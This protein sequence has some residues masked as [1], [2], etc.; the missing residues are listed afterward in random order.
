MHR[1]QILHYN[2][3]KKYKKKMSKFRVVYKITFAA[4][5]AAKC[6]TKTIKEQGINPE[7]LQT[8]REDF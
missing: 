7:E 5:T 4:Q 3:Q 2:I 1:T 8:L 6:K